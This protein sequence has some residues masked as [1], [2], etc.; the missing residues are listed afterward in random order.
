MIFQSQKHIFFPLAGEKVI[1]L[2][3]FGFLYT[4][5]LYWIA[6]YGETRTA[7]FLVL[8]FF[9][10]FQMGVCRSAPTLYIRI[11]FQEYKPS[12][13]KLHTNRTAHFWFLRKLES[14]IP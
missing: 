5:K 7:F 2:V 6:W 9:F 3:S 1:I 13:C 12:I 4:A 14:Q 11:L 8:Y 10:C